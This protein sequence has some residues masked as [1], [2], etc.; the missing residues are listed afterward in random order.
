MSNST[1]LL[2]SPLAPVSTVLTNQEQRDR[3]SGLVFMGTVLTNW[4]QQDAASG[5]KLGH[6]LMGCIKVTCLAV[7]PSLPAMHQ[8]HPHHPAPS[9]LPSSSPS[10]SSPAA[11]AAAAGSAMQTSSTPLWSH[12]DLDEEQQGASSSSL[13]SLQAR[14]LVEVAEREWLISPQGLPVRPVA[15]V[16]EQLPVERACMR[17]DIEDEPSYT[18]AVTEEAWVTVHP[19]GTLKPLAPSDVSRR[20]QSLGLSNLNEGQQW[21][22]GVCVCVCGLEPRPLKL[23]QGPAVDYVGMCVCMCETRCASAIWVHV[24]G[25]VEV[26]ERALCV[27]VCMVI[28]MKARNTGAGAGGAAAR[29]FDTFGIA[30]GGV[31]S[32]MLI[33]KANT[34]HRAVF[35]AFA[36]SLGHQEMQ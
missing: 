27:L 13:P 6:V 7:G 19:D 1:V 18:A 29:Q 21:I 17:Y 28:T 4:Q 5:L 32:G 14:L 15:P 20:A 22:L 2:R 24:W 26:L 25:G 33:R 34:A 3:A 23:R 36:K 8:P 16:Q 10:S 11:A 9:T 31:L 30:S 12:S 35:A